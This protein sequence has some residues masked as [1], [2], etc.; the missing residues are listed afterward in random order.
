MEERGEN[1]EISVRLK[2]TGERAGTEVA[3]LYIRDVAA[4]LVRPVK[5]LK[6]YCRVALAPGEEREL[7][8]TLPKK[9]LGFYDN[10]GQYRLEDGLFR[11]FVGGSSR[12]VL[13]RE[14][15]VSFA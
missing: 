6:D 1:L 11:I 8:F 12:D 10:A 4:S 15:R 7:R 3:Q 13:E 14:L 5:E 9:D 2:N